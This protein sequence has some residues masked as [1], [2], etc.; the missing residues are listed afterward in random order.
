LGKIDINPKTNAY[1]RH[2][3]KNCKYATLNN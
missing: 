3:N 1:I 2:C